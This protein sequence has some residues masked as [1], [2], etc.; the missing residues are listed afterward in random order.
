MPKLKEIKNKFKLLFEGDL[1]T[2]IQKVKESLHCE[3]KLYD[4]FVMLSAQIVGLN[5]DWHRQLVPYHDYILFTNKIRSGALSIVNDLTAVD[6]TG[7][8]NEDDINEKHS[9]IKEDVPYFERISNGEFKGKNGEYKITIAPTVFF[10]YRLEGAFPGV[11][12]LKWFKGE[13]AIKR[14]KLL[15][16][17]PIRFNIANG[18][19]LLAVP[20][21]WFRGYSEMPIKRFEL[22]S[23]SKCLLNENELKI[24]KV[25]A[26]NSPYH[27]RCFVYVEV[28][29]EQP[30][31]LYNYTKEQIEESTKSIGYCFEQ[32]G[33]HNGI[34]IRTEEYDDG[35]AEI[36]GEI[37]DTPDAEVRVRFLTS[38]NFIIVAKSSPFNSSEGNILLGEFMNGILK[39]EKT[40]EEFAEKAA[41]L[42]KNWMDVDV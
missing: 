9:E 7:I 16:R 29:G 4:D 24:T 40:L 39:G 13:T 36:N 15:L 2:A 37:V 42:K 27:Y 21:W 26:Y 22:L 3:S 19:G 28:E 31:G 18:D 32:Y 30:I 12:G 23:P 14:L 34:P 8:E 41:K 25:A 11:R 1:E 35:A 33:L 38:Y 5:K 17:E 20:I 10:S 6:L